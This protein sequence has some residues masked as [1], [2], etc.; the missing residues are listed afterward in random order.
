MPLVLLQL[1]LQFLALMMPLRLAFMMPLLQLQLL[2]QL[3]ALM[4]LL[5]FLLLLMQ[6]P[7][8][9]LLQLLLRLVALMMPLLLMLLLLQVTLK[10]E[11]DWPGRPFPFSLSPALPLAVAGLLAALPSITGTLRYLFSVR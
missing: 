2:L 4:M 3:L 1:L 8:Q 5:V 6:L 11:F 7:L 9:L 10:V